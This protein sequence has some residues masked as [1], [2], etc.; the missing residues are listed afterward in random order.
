MGMAQT[1]A[2]PDANFEQFLLDEGIDTDGALNGQITNADAQAVTDLDIPNLGI[3]DLAGLEAFV[4]LVNFESSRNQFPTIPTNSLILLEELIIGG[5]SAITSL[6][7]SNNV[8]LVLLKMTR[9]TSPNT[10]PP[11]L[12]RLIL[13]QILT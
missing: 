12:Q 6:E 4:N 2:I 11:P 9:E 1:T 10:Y 5:N 13:L 8:E 7:L 3:T